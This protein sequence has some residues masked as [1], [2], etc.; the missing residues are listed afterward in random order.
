MAANE[1]LL[2]SN[3]MRETR[4]TQFTQEKIT[5]SILQKHVSTPLLYLLV[6]LPGDVVPQQGAAVLLVVRPQVLVL[7]SG[8][9]GQERGRPDL[10]GGEGG[11]GGT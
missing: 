2:S 6:Q 10:V 9:V 11:G 1:V 4:L 8:L 5:R 3:A 7:H